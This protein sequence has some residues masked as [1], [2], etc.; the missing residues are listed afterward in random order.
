MKLELAE[1]AACLNIPVNTVERWIRQGKIPVKK[2]DKHCLF[3]EE[4]LEKWAEKHN[5]SLSLSDHLKDEKKE[6]EKNQ[7]TL[8]MRRG[9]LHY[10]IP[11]NSVQDV[12]KSAVSLVPDMSDRDREILYTKLIEREK[13]SSTGIGKGIAIPHPR[14]PMTGTDKKVFITTCFLK[15]KVDFGA[16]D[17]KPVSVI[18]LLVCPSIKSHLYFL[19]RISF[20]LRDNS[21]INF[22]NSTPTPEMFYEKI[23][24]FEKDLEKAEK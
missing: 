1:F 9:G 11:G 14:R 19:S 24:A 5:I 17:G 22:L 4:L 18:F 6:S 12:L 16:I 20:C 13:L 8:A 2:A 10:D 3:N 15:N 21:F 23:K 7:L